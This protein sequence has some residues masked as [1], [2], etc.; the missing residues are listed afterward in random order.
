MNLFKV[1]VVELRNAAE[2][3]FVKLCCAAVSAT[4][5]LFG[6]GKAGAPKGSLAV[7]LGDE[8][9]L[10][11]LDLKAQLKDVGGIGGN[12]STDFPREA[13]AICNILRAHLRSGVADLSDPGGLLPKDLEAIR[14]SLNVNVSHIR[15][16]QYTEPNRPWCLMPDAPVARFAAEALIRYLKFFNSNPE[17]IKYEPLAEC[18]YCEGIFLI[19]KA[20]QR[21]CKDECRQLHWYAERGKEYYSTSQRLKRQ[22]IRE[23]RAK[24]VNR[25]D[26]RS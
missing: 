13:K 6:E 10:R 9:I 8:G 20:G 17:L 26:R 1:R 18:L 7:I 15:P 21:F 19:Q 11:E 22:K 25:P 23:R 3:L 16:L 24:A 14:K 12:G 2:D 5:E 4:P